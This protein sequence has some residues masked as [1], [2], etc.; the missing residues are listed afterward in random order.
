MKEE[1]LREVEKRQWLRRIEEPTVFLDRDGRV[2]GTFIPAG[3]PPPTEPPQ[4]PEA[5]AAVGARIPK[6]PPS[7]SPGNAALY[8]PDPKAEEIFGVSPSMSS[9]YRDGSDE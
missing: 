3:S 7:G 6:Y 8:R 5:S 2:I 9:A 4:P 1:T